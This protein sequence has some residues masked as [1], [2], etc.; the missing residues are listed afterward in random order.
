M[1]DVDAVLIVEYPYSR[2]EVC[3]VW[4]VQIDIWVTI[5]KLECFLVIGIGYRYR[6]V[7]GAAHV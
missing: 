3:Q 4:W 7:G 2:G 1:S 6:D 5:A